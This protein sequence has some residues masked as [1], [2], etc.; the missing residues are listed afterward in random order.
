MR[1]LA[2]RRATMRRL[3][4]RGLA[5]CALMGLAACDTGTDAASPV[6]VRD[7]LAARLAGTDRTAAFEMPSRAVLDRR[8]T[9]LL[10]M[11]IPALG[12][13]ATLSPVA[14]NAG[15]VTWTALD[16]VSVATRGGLIVAT[17]GLGHDLMSADAGQVLTALNRGG[18]RATR[19]HYRLDGEDRTE[20]LRFACTIRAEGEERI[21][22][23]G[24]PVA[25]RRLSESCDGPVGRFTNR[26]WIDAAGRMAQSRQWLVPEIGAATTQRLVD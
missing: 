25:T 1:R 10:Y 20:A 16:G 24:R 23:V 5:L 4:M 26:Y 11:A 2:M 18:G 8:A 14:Q 13:Q 21:G 19:I 22:I 15:T 6:T 7:L 12:A 3:T 9:P 17:R